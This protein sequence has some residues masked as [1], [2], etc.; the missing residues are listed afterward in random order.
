MSAESQDHVRAIE[1]AL[2]EL[3]RGQSRHRLQHRD[4]E[5]MRGRHDRSLGAAARF[6]MLEALASANGRM[7]VSDLAQA[8]GVD[9]PRASRLVADATE[10]GLV[11]RDV[12]PSDARRSSIELTDGGR[13]TLESAHRNRRVAVTSALADFTPEETATFAALLA[14]FANSWPRD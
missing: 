1:Q 5:R 9:Q 8:I 3:R 6:R 2:L 13:E 14:R 11:R 10:H 4:R 7:G 12:D